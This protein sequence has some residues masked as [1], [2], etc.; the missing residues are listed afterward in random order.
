MT[1]SPTRSLGDL[2]L[3]IEAGKSPQCDTRPAAADEWGVIKVSA[4]TYSRFLPEEN[5]ALLPGAK[6]DVKHRIRAGDLLLSRANTKA[7]VGGV[8]MVPS[9]FEAQLL[10]CDKSLRLVL[11]EEQL[12]PTWLLWAL[13]SPGARAQIEAV[14]T[15]TKD[16]MRN[17]SQANVRALR[18]QVPELEVQRAQAER[19]EELEAGWIATQTAIGYVQRRV[20]AARLSAINYVLGSGTHD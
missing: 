20:R 19:L 13:R 10:L 14:A 12:D 4:M 16:S 8:V 18:L 11:C 9:D 7:Y 6:F 17:I 2:L 1:S 15:G 5:K 3:R